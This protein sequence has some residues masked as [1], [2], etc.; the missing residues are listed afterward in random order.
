[1]SKIIVVA[2]A[3]GG[4]GKTTTSLYIAEL[5][6]QH[7]IKNHSNR[8]VELRDSDPQGSATEWYQ[9]IANEVDF[10]FSITNKR[11]MGLKN[12]LYEYIVIDTPPADVSI[13]ESAIAIADLV[14]I[15][16]APSGLDL[17]RTFDVLDMIKNDKD[18]KVLFTKVD[19]RT[20]TYKSAKEL[21]EV[22]NINMFETYIPKRESII[23]SFSSKPEDDYYYKK[24]VEEIIDWSNN[25]EQ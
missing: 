9:K 8:N 1:M 4:V 7:L 3:K 19:N 14:I 17:G 20:L 12:D 2:N 22:E 16:T 13:M 5:L 11:S 15:P 6:Q 23:R 10:S 21:L 25:Y 18:Y 24:V